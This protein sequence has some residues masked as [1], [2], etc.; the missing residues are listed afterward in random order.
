MTWKLTAPS[1]AAVFLSVC[2]VALCP[3]TTYADP[4]ISAAGDIAC[5]SSIPTPN[6]CHQQATSNLLSGS[7][8]VLS[9]G[10]NQYE[11]G[12]S[13]EFNTYYDPTWGR[14]KSITYAVPGDHEYHTEGAA[15]H[16]A[17]FGGS[18]GYYS[19][20]IGGWHMVAL[21]SE[22]AHDTESPQEQWLKADLAA[23]DSRC[24]LAYWHKPRFTSGTGPSSDGS[25]DAFWRDLYAARTEVVLN[26]DVHNYERFRKQT[27]D[28]VPN[29]AYGIREFVVGTGG[30]E[31]VPS[32]TP[33]ENS[34]YQAER[35]GVLRLTL[36]PTSYDWAFVREDGT[37]E[38]VHTGLRCPG[39][40]TPPTTGP[41][42]GV[43]DRDFSAT[44]FDDEAAIGFNLID[45]DPSK[46]EMDALHGR[47]LK[48]LVW[49]GDY[50]NT[51]CSFNESDDWI[52]SRVSAVAGNPGVGAYFISD[53]PNA[54][55]CP[56]APNQTRARSD[57][58][59]SI[60]PDPPTLMVD[61]KVD[62]YKLWAGTTDI[63][64]LNHYP[65]SIQNG[66]DYSKIDEE[67]AEADRLGIRYWGVIQAFGDD[68][69]KVPTPDEVHQQFVHWGNTEMEGYLV[70]AW[71]WPSN[72]PSLWL[73]NHPELRFQLAVENALPTP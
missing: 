42:R 11:D 6:A 36:H 58:V 1:L 47:G 49:L 56:N 44:G 48:G 55:T 57:L 19:F 16:F 26:G 37:T 10:N 31:L 72:D 32:G 14:Y 33:I 66:C 64:G 46:E 70:F 61:Y 27:P 34:V 5:A 41:I 12:T 8:A 53:E 4:V 69:Y 43:F 20:D 13:S 40:R 7:T 39:K 73:A 71:H 60:D 62:Q 29:R 38:D 25:F 52:R 22:I 59:K 54:I 30:R 23:S 65:C 3:T 45:S 15:G 24:T 63:L 67:V 50:S 21:N 68:W 35:F 51:T 17:Y 2:T 9:L 28:Q 18:R